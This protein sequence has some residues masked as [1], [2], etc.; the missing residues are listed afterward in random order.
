MTYKVKKGDTLSAIAKKY[1]TTVAELASANG[2]KNPNK[3][4]VGKVLTIPVKETDVKKALDDCLDAIEALPE[5]KVL[6][7]L[8]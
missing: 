8:M 3:I 6:T 4:S 2:I 5:F 1:K 7:E